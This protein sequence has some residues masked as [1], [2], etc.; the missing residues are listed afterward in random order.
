MARSLLVVVLS[1]L[2]YINLTIAQSTTTDS[3]SA[4]T[5]SASYNVFSAI[6]SQHPGNNHG[7]PAGSVGGNTQGEQ[8]Q[9]AAGA[10]GGSESSVNLSTGAQIGIIVSVA[11]V[12][13]IG[14]KF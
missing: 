6:A 10:S 8:G 12:V 14:G 13:I 2:S 4:S 5:A 3:P 7:D 1:I 11:L 9:N